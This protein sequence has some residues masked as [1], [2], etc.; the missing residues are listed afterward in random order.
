MVDY[1]ISSLLGCK[2]IIR[3]LC[4]LRVGPGAAGAGATAAAARTRYIQAVLT[5]QNKLKPTVI[6]FKE[7]A[8]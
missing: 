7:V 5:T 4:H 8:K 3:I 2:Y 1:V 6:C